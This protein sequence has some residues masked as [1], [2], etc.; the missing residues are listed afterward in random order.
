[1]IRV[2]L[3]L[4]TRLGRRIALLFVISSLVPVGTMAVLAYLQMAPRAVADATEQLRR[5]QGSVGMGIVAQLDAAVNVLYGIPAEAL[6]GG[7]LTRTGAAAMDRVRPAFRSLAVQRGT[8]FRVLRGEPPAATLTPAQAARADSGKTVLLL[9]DALRVWIVAPVGPDMRLWG[10]VDTTYLFSGID[11]RTATDSGTVSV[12]I[13]ATSAALPLR[14]PAAPAELQV[15]PDRAWPVFLGYDFGVPASDGWTVRVSEPR[16]EVLAPVSAFR[17][18]FGLII[19]VVIGLVVLLTTFQVRRSL[20][21][22]E[23]LRD[24]MQRVGM[25]DF[26][27]VVEVASGDE[28]EDL[29]HTFNNMAA[30]IDEQ[31]RAITA[32]SAIDQAA[33]VSNRGIEVAATAATRL[34]EA[35]RCRRVDV[36]LAGERAGDA[37]RRVSR[38]NGSAGADGEFRLPPAALHRLGSEP[39]LRLRSGADG[40]SWLDRAG[41][42]GV[43]DALLPLWSHDELVGLIAVHTDGPP[44]DAQARLVRQLGD[45]L[46]VGLANSRLIDRLNGLS[47]GALAALA[48]S[49]DANSHWTAGHSERVTALSMR[50]ARCLRLPQPTLETLY[51]GGLLHDIGKIGVPNSVLDFPGP[52]DDAGLSAIRRHPE[53][54]AEI[55]API[56]AFADAAGGATT[57]RTWRASSPLPTSTMRWCRIDPTGPAGSRQRPSNGSGP[58]LASTSIP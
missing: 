36:C 20:Q 47:Y 15:A 52:L 44:S 22:L 48:R 32:G 58:R 10:A 49:V 43:P 1:V 26:S 50:I 40:F 9:D 34:R 6:A 42:G 41:D 19:V 39:G 13:R 25:R 7:R 31:F 4:Q 23:R 46:S 18:T 21:P 2:P 29:A 14:C 27:G 8:A 17:R 3:T 28:F 30:E 12:C 45:Q 54:G 55:L 35:L 56:A 53:L 33:L 37:W 11:A 38:T 24:G 51:R 5:M 57:S 16:S